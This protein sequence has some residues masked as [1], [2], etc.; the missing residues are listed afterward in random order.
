[1]GKIKIYTDGSCDI[2]VR[3]NDNIGGFAFIILDSNNSIINEGQGNY[4]NSTNN[5]M[6]IM[7]VIEAI[8]NLPVEYE[9][10][11]IFSDSQY[12]VNTI[13]KNWKKKANIDLWNILCPLINDKIKLSWV[14]G[15]SGNIYNEYC[16]RMADKQMDIKNIP[17]DLIN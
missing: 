9:S 7:A 13:M 4:R 8:K 5:R 1:M 2:N 16:D 17:T 14:K 3:G 11:E 12:V 10:V 15:H 6:E